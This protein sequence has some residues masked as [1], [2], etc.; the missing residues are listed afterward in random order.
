MSKYDSNTPRKRLVYLRRVLGLTQKEFS[1][2]T[3][4]PHRSLQK[5]EYGEMILN[6]ETMFQ[7]AS[8]LNIPPS[9]FLIELD[10]CHNYNLINEFI[11]IDLHNE[12]IQSLKV[13]LNSIQLNKTARS[14]LVSENHLKKTELN[15]TFQKQ[16]S[17]SSSKYS[18]GFNV[19]QFDLLALGFEYII[20]SK[21]RYHLGIITHNFDNLK[22]RT[23]CIIRVKSSDKEKPITL[24]Y[25]LDISQIPPEKFIN[26][27]YIANKLSNY[28]G[29]KIEPLPSIT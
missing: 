3:K 1:N 23:I 28:I 7:I 15:K 19:K 27:A 11:D 29:E 20:R 8:K 21:S 18:F 9:Y 25:H 10:K 26:T 5:L 14:L 12:L 6:I 4:I 16:L 24:A 17:L 2:K 13:L 22:T